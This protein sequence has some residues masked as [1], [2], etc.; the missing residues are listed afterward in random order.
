MD[1]GVAQKMN[2]LI[3]ATEPFNDSSDVSDTS[4]PLSNYISLAISSLKFIF[5]GGDYI[6]GIM[7]LY[8]RGS[9][10]YESYI[11]IQKLH[12]E[13]RA[14]NIH[15]MHLP[16]NTLPQNKKW[17]PGCQCE[18]C[19]EYDGKDKAITLMRCAVCRDHF[20]NMMPSQDITCYYDFNVKYDSDNSD[21]SGEEEIDPDHVTV[22][23]HNRAGLVGNYWY[24]P[25][26]G[27][28]YEQ[29]R[30]R[31]SHDTTIPIR[32]SDYSI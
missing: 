9:T 4:S 23:V 26:W 14:K 27:S 31:A 24:D 17:I 18:T 16:F 10:W 15:A 30:R 25:L 32:F 7:C 11:K 8:M 2:A 22:T 28:R 29:P 20:E 21:D 13:A 1:L 6:G 5:G 19:K 12:W 3:Q